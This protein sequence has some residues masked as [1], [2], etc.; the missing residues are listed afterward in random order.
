[1]SSTGGLNP[2]TRARLEQE[3]AQLQEQHAELAPRFGEESVGDSA[4]QADMLERA[5]T[6]AWMERRMH[7]IRELLRSGPDAEDYAVAPGT[8]VKLR[9]ADGSED[10]MRIIAIAEE[11]V[12]DA[13]ALTLDSP[14]GKAVAAHGP[15]DKITYRTPRG[16]ATAEILEM[17]PP[18]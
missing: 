8:E 7:E 6:A 12:D 3:L 10:T 18:K 4:D 13:D 14:L 2:A 16:E 9:F 15:G 17:T 1:M 5:E 11:A